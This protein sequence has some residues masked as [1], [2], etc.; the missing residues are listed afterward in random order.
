M[1]VLPKGANAA[2]AAP[3]VQAV[4]GWTAGAGAPDVDVSALLLTADGKV[5]SDGDFV[6]YNA[7][8]HA[9]GAVS[10]AGKQPAAAGPVTDAVAVDLPAI[11]PAIDRIALAAST[12]GEP[13]GRVPG[14]HLRILDQATGAELIRFDDM[15][16]DT[17]TAFV[18][19]EFYRRGG[20]WKFRAVGQGWDSGLAGLATDFG[21]SVDEPAA[22]Q[23]SAALPTP[24]ALPA[25][26]GAPVS[27]TKAE[28]LVRLEKTLA[29]RGDQ[30]LLDLTKRAAMSLSKRGLG[31]HTARVAICLDISGSMGGLY[32]AGKIQALAE[33]VLALGMRFDD[34]SSI[35]CFLFGANSHTAGAMTLDNYRTHLSEVLRRH[36]LEGGTYYGKALT[37]IREH[38]FG[39]AGPR[40]GPHSG[41][42]VYVM[43]ITDGATFDK[44]VT[45][46]QIQSSSYEP[47]F[48][49]FMGIG[50][51]PAR[52]GGFLRR[53]RGGGEFT[54]LEELDDMP[55][56]FLDNTDFFAVAD[57]LEMSD[58]ALFDLLMTEY[59]GWLTQAGARGITS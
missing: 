48:I 13:I 14:L 22:P 43:F 21:I 54:F 18:L 34:D 5:R 52:G 37:R 39:S 30:H 47:M 27:L 1:T 59:P 19:G 35:D 7:P 10:H 23:A 6:F 17:E 38:Y 49:Q 32:R 55:G 15:R 9:S 41:P 11:E 29:D 8:R 42:P 2:V 56:R 58:D 12:D 16:A 24:P 57:P 26:A 25:P 31:E 28:K 3:S 33:R 40:S 53:S 4:L 46:A 45:R 51:A 20:A 44:D 36:A 50:E